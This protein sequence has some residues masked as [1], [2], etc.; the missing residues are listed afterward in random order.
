[1]G[2]QAVCWPPLGYLPMAGDCSLLQ[3]L[4]APLGVEVMAVLEGGDVAVC[5]S[6]RNVVCA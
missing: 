1:M 4:F 3:S 2:E 5:A 6:L